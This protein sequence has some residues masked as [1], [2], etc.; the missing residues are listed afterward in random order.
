MLRIFTQ[1]FPKR[2]LFLLVSENLLI[3]GTIH[4]AAL[5]MAGDDGRL[6][7]GLVPKS[8]LI[9]LVCQLS[10]HYN[11]LYNLQLIKDGRELV[12]RLLQS[13]G[14]SSILVAT[15]YLFFPSMLLGQGVFA[16]A[17]LI[18]LVFL[19]LWRVA[20]SRMNQLRELKRS[21]LI[22]GTGELAR[23]LAAEIL[24]RPET[25][26]RIAGFVSDDVEMVGQSIVNPLV[27]GHTG[28]L[29]DLLEKEKA[30]TVIVAMPQSRGTLPVEELL[31]LKLRGVFIED[32]TSLYEKITGKIAV[33]NLRPSLLIF[34]E[35]FKK[36][37]LTHLYKRI[38]GVV[39]SVIGLI[40][41]FPV[42]AVV[43]IMIK[44]ESAG[45]VLFR[46]K[47]A[48]ENGRIFELLKFRSMYED[49]EAQSGPVWAQ[50]N[51][52]RVTRVGR[53]IRSLRLDELP[54]FINVLRGDM[55]FVGPRPERPHFVQQLSE[56]IPYYNQRHSV[57]PG[58]TGWAQIKFRYG[59]TI[60]DTIEKLRYDL[61]YIKN[62]SIWLDA[63]IIFQTIK[64]VLLGKGV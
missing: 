62:M 50:Q 33:E 15:I 30:T 10:L 9:T 2:T 20:F 17:V 47:R 21:A 38:S 26:I 60:E 24:S 34:S 27:L 57:K 51:D 52:A 8:L 39:F 11:D 43:A 58:I 13:L 36:S 63:F 61:F 56:I 19:V 18:L 46:Q 31:D 14:V 49:A 54:Q 1:Y 48:G 41:F 7:E 6:F 44:L 3:L 59:N 64:I 4:L 32:A 53:W 25:G 35:G 55:N 40:I 28:Q 16:L 12:I 37:Q 42:M 45:P 23:K 22:L 29:R 5:I